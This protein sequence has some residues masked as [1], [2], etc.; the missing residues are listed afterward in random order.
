MDGDFHMRLGME[1]PRDG[2]KVRPHDDLGPRHHEPE[3]G[4]RPRQADLVVVAEA[5][6]NRIDQLLG[7][8]LQVHHGGGGGGGGDILPGARNELLA[9][10]FGGLLLFVFGSKLLVSNLAFNVIYC[11][12]GFRE[13]T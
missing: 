11:V 5:G 12:E 6:G 10:C 9:Y 2:G 1:S 13:L 4:V 8:V 7:E 3:V